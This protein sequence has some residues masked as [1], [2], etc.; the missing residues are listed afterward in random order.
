MA[1]K[2]TIFVMSSMVNTTLTI[3]FASLTK[4]KRQ[5]LKVVFAFLETFPFLKPCLRIAERNEVI[6]VTISTEEINISE[7]PQILKNITEFI[8]FL[9]Q[10]GYVDTDLGDRMRDAALSGVK[11]SSPTIH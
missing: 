7:H 1:T 9:E 5:R 11:T 8:D 6:Y 4:E 10:Q 3:N 2:I